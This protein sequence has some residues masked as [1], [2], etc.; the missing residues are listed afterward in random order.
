MMKTVVITDTPFSDNEAEMIRIILSEGIDR[1][2]IRK[3]G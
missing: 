2:H 1:V 3:P